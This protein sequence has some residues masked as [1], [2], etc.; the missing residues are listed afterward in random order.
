V[1]IKPPIK[2]LECTSSFVKKEPK[3]TRGINIASS[4]TSVLDSQASHHHLEAGMVT[5]NEGGDSGA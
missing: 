4:F 3:K 5:G 2:N 1:K